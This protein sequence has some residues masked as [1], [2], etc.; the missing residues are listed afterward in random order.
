[1]IIVILFQACPVH[2]FSHYHTHILQFEGKG[3]RCHGL[4]KATHGALLFEVRLKPET[5]WMG[6]PVGHHASFVLGFASTRPFLSNIL[7]L[8]SPSLPQKSVCKLGVGGGRQKRH[9]CGGVAPQTK[10]CIKG[11]CAQKKQSNWLEKPKLCHWRLTINYR[12][13]HPFGSLM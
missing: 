2:Y 11:K 3:L 10:P 7:R 1:M 8:G 4:P 9:I 5:T 13:I 6:L 12:I